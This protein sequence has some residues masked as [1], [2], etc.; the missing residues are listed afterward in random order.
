MIRHGEAIAIYRDGKPLGLCR[1]TEELAPV[2]HSLVWLECAD[3]HG[4]F[5]EL[6]AGVISPGPRGTGGGCILLPAQ[7]GSGKTTLTAALVHDGWNYL[8]D[9]I[10]LLDAATMRVAP[11]PMAFCLKRSGLAAVAE[12]WP[13]AR[14]LMFHLREDGKRV[15]YLPPPIERVVSPDARM[16]VRAI[17]F[18]RYR[19][20][21]ALA[22]NIL[23]PLEGLRRVA[24]DCVAISGRLSAAHVQALVNWIAKIPC[25]DVVYGSTADALSAMRTVSDATHS[26]E[27]RQ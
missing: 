11:V 20:D 4:F 14:D 26:T 6:H 10:A 24:N 7:P 15:A 12:F 8:S 1:A 13:A 5:L 27:M 18:P 17:V 16:E 19:K 22:C 2:V 9:E 3:L 25:Y 21:R 23:S